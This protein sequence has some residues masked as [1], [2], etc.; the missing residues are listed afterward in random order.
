MCRGMF[1]ANQL[2]RKHPFILNAKIEPLQ[3][4]KMAVR[5]R[6]PAYAWGEVLADIKANTGTFVIDWPCR[7]YTRLNMQTYTEDANGLL[8]RLS[9]VCLNYE[10]ASLQRCT[11]SCAFLHC[12]YCKGGRPDAK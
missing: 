4:A 11:D 12:L 10:R 1:P 5:G 2:A 8:L 3:W 9:T 7:L 6:L